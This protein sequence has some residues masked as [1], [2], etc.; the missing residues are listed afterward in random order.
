MN[1]WV[2]D[3]FKFDFAMGY[4]WLICIAKLINDENFMTS[5]IKKIR[6]IEE[7]TNVGYL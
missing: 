7:N 4:Y 2:N 6:Q 3:N 1:F 5:L